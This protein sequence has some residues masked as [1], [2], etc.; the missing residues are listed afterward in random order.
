MIGPVY[1]AP[2]ALGRVGTHRAQS[3]SARHMPGHM[4]RV[5]RVARRDHA[6]TEAQRARRVHEH[7]GSAPDTLRACRSRSAS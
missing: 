3:S 1:D 2:V 6:R 7:A 5:C 4:P